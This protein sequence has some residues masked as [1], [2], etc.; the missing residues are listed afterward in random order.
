MNKITS[1]LALSWVL[2]L[3]CSAES[4]HDDRLQ[5]DAAPELDLGPSPDLSLLPDLAPKSCGTIAVCLLGCGPSIGICQVSCVSGA[6]PEALQ[7]AG[8]IAACAARNCIAASDGGTDVNVA[9][10][11]LLSKCSREVANCEGFIR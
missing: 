8:A 9:I 4:N 10:V 5:L 11:C 1:A 6:S 2:L 7:Q 3:G